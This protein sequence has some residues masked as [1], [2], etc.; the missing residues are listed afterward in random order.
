M[1]I[2]KEN[3]S[4][5]PRITQ[6]KN[7]I[8]RSLSYR[9]T[10]SQTDT[11]VNTEDTLLGFPDFFLQAIIKERSNIAHDRHII[12]QNTATVWLPSIWQR[13]IPAKSTLPRVAGRNNRFCNYYRKV[14]KLAFWNEL[15]QNLTVHISICVLNVQMYIYE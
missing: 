6:S 12:S 2:S 3:I 1:K 13:H 5:L 4:H 8:P 15:M 14:Y 9:H 11:R 7:Q 10:D